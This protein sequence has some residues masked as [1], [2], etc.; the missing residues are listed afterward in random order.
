MNPN[1]R[2]ILWSTTLAAVLASAFLA[3]GGESEPAA[4]RPQAAPPAAPERVAAGEAP[5]AAEDLYQWDPAAGPRRDL[6]AD[7]AGCQAE[8]TGPGLSGVAQH[9]QCMQRLGWKT[10]PPG[11]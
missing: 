10:R 6:A 2:R 11:S 9:I 7:T 5:F 4:D 8:I 1:A 3:C